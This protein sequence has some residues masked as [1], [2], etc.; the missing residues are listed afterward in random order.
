MTNSTSAWMSPRPNPLGDL[1]Y[2][3]NPLVN[4]GLSCPSLYGLPRTLHHCTNSTLT[5]TS[6]ICQ[7]L[8]LFD[9]KRLYFNI[10]F[11]P[12]VYSSQDLHTISTVHSVTNSTTAN[13]WKEMFTGCLIKK[14]YPFLNLYFC[15]T[16]EYSRKRQISMERMEC[17]SYLKT[18]IIF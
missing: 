4:G 7:S 16:S 5:D 1:V 8:S 12:L 10:I 13:I 15:K 11:T 14:V 9:P 18:V 2:S 3:Q 17:D 6:D